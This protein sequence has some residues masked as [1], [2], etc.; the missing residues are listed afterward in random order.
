M[1]YPL[2]RLARVHV[3][4]LDL[5]S[6]SRATGLHPELVRRLVALGLIDTCPGLP[7]G[8]CFPPAQVAAAGRLQRL[9]AGLAVNYA[10]LGLVTDLLDRIAELEAALRTRTRWTGDRSWT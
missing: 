3:G 2:V 8:L 4:H 9:R 6:F 7:G 5:E 10:S 1:T